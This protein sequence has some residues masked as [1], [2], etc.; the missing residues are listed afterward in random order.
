MSRRVS[1]KTNFVSIRVCVCEKD[2][3]ASDCWPRKFLLSSEKQLEVWNS[4]LAKRQSQLAHNWNQFK[5]TNQFISFTPEKPQIIRWWQ[6]LWERLWFNNLLGQQL[7]HRM[8]IFTRPVS[9]Q[10]IKFQAIKPL[11]LGKILSFFLQK[12]H[13]NVS[14]VS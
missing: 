14:K 7:Y 1:K 6:L 4:Q 3:W 9:K 13:P 12:L 11:D 8:V 2:T 5:P 10:Y